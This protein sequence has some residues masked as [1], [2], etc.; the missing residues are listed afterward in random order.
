MKNFGIIEKNLFVDEEVLMTF[1]GLHNLKVITA[2][3][4]TNKR[5]LMAEKRLMGEMFQ[6]ILM[7]N[8]ND[9]TLKTGLANGRLLGGGI[10]TIDTS[11]KKF[12]IALK[13]SAENVNK[14]INKITY[15][16]KN[17]DNKVERVEKP[18]VYE[19]EE[20]KELLDMGILTQEEFD[21]Q[22]SKVLNKWKNT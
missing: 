2:Y 11:K 8:L 3:A 12:D 21:L 22:K 10:I 1:I 6:V 19:L 17:K 15:S 13:Q 9:I 20:L 5:I 4:I 18:V 14:K 7:D 16:V